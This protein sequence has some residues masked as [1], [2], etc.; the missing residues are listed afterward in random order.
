[1]I[2]EVKTMKKITS[3]VAIILA[4]VFV[5]QITAPT[6][7]NAGKNAAAAALLSCA[8]PG[9]G[10]WYNSNYTN[11]SFPWGEC[12]V[13]KICVCF[14]ISSVFD[15]VEGDTSS[16]MRFDFWAVPPKASQ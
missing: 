16:D 13:G 9:A 11:G 14:A 8:I 10:E 6:N 3:V 7:A 12:I 1:M 15:A 2:K 5:L 4:L